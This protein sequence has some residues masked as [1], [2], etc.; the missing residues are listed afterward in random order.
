MP[1]HFRPKDLSLS[2]VTAGLVA[3]LVGYTSSAAI[4]Y[5]ALAAAGAGHELIGGWLT[6]LGLAMGI[7]SI[8]LSLWYRQPILTA[9]STPGAALLV[10]SLAGTSP[11]QAVGIFVFASALIFVTGITG[12]FARV[13]KFIPQALSAA[14]LAGI[15]LRFG[16]DAFLSLQSH[17]TLAASICLTYFVARRLLPRYAMLCALA[18]GV[19]LAGWQGEIR[20]LGQAL[21]VV[22]PVWITPEFDVNTLIGIGIP[23]FLVT[24]ASQ[25]APG[26]ATLTAAGYPPAVSPLIA[27][28]GLTSLLLAPLGGFSV[29]VAAI[30]A[31]VCQGEEAHPDARRRYMATVSAGV[32]YLLAGLLGGSI[33]LLLSAV[34]EALI[35]T[36]AGL[37]LLGTIAGS[38]QRALQHEAHREAANVTFLVT[39]SGLTL[40]GIGSAFWGLVAGILTWLLLH[41]PLRRSK[42]ADTK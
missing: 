23:F 18:I 11:A 36:I 40:F 28:T 30:S 5:Q 16:L 38:L 14:M 2:A 15:L 37:A 8:G 9:W 4:I 22:L 26:V 13:M 27:A 10:T 12:I 1:V 3:V 7:S 29:C 33:G 35:H 39:A 34:P 17:F 19:A 41:M 21:S 25:N 6:M 32:F 20:P 42:S 31:A 24:M